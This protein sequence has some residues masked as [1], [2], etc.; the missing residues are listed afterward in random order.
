MKSIELCSY[1]LR[2]KENQPSQMRC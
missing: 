2:K 1:Q